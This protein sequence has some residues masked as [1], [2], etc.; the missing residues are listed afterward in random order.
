MNFVV[1]SVFIASVC[2][3]YLEG[4]CEEVRK[5]LHHAFPDEE[6]VA[7]FVSGIRKISEQPAP[8]GRK[9]LVVT[10][11]QTGSEGSIIVRRADADTGDYIR[12]H[13]FHLSGHV[14]VSQDGK[15]VFQ[16]PY[17]PEESR[18]VENC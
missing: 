2:P 17:I 11:T 18:Y 9:S 8:T 7:R 4:I 10:H 15:K 6:S 13:Y 14:C 5:T 3:K 12:I 1:D 16:H